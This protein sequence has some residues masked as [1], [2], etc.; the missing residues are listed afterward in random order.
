MNGNESLLPDD[1]TALPAEDL[2]NHLARI[3]ARATE[4]RE[5][6][7]N[8]ELTDETLAEI[9][10]LADQRDQLLGETTRRQAEA[11]DRADRAQA[12]LGR[13]TAPPVAAAPGEGEEEEEAG[14]GAGEGG[15]GG[16]GGEARAAA[17]VEPTA[18]QLVALPLETVEALTQLAT[19]GR[20]ATPAAP[21][22]RSPSALTAARPPA[23]RPKSTQQTFMS[24]TAHSH[25]REGSELTDT[26]AVAEL[27]ADARTRMGN[28]P[29]GVSGDR[30]SMAFAR[31]ELDGEMLSNDPTKNFGILRNAVEA[32]LVASSGDP[33]LVASGGYGYCNI[34]T[35]MYEFYRLA[36]RQTPIEDDLPTIPAPRAGIQYMQPMDWRA[37]IAATG[38]Q[39]KAAQEANEVKSFLKMTCPAILTAEVIAVYQIVQFDN[40]QYR[41]FTEQAESFLEDVAVGFDFTKESYYLSQIASKSTS[42]TGEG[43]YGAARGLLYDWVTEG[44]EYRKRNAMRRDSVLKLYVPDWSLDMI[45]LD[46]SLDNSE[47]LQRRAV[48]DAEAVAEI[49][50]HNFD[51]VF[52][53]DLT[54]TAGGIARPQAAGALN[55]WPTHVKAYIHSPGSFG[56]LDAGTLDVG[57]VRDSVLNGT[58]DVQM[59]M[60]EW[61]GIAFLG[62]ESIELITPVCISGG[63]PAYAALRSCA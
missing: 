22:R 55:S 62:L 44:T 30:V 49:R 59:F 4:L 33:A 42:V 63:A 11:D 24:A 8:G 34:Y 43:P 54:A 60:E 38:T 46:M 56:R 50:A 1:L 27:M 29:T 13:L 14:A 17:A 7:D 3:D 12:G 31:K 10:Q 5:A 45:K 57:L 41:V 16:E 6:A 9:E 40:L 28:V 32:A 51:P 53:N 15:E 61:L 2:T 21:A 23:A 18:P 26:H 58:N 39:D 37:A 52:Y 36:E 48:T 47:G 35:P 20:E 25:I 19:Q